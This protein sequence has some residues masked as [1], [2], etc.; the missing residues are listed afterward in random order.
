MNPVLVTL[1]GNSPASC[2]AVIGGGRGPAID[3]SEY[4][5]LGFDW[6][7]LVS[8]V[9]NVVGKIA[10]KVGSARAQRQQRE[11]AAATARLKAI[12]AQKRKVLIYAGIGGGVLLLAGGALLLSRKRGK[13]GNR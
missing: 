4:P 1:Y 11:Q 7:N 10:G 8:K 13:R 2:R 3:I 9:G 6:A 12:S 5:E